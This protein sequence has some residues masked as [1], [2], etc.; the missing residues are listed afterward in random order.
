MPRFEPFNA[1][2][3][4]G[5][6]LVVDNNGAA[7]FDHGRDVK[8]MPGTCPT[9]T[10]TKALVHPTSFERYRRALT[11]TEMIHRMEQQY[12]PDA[13][14]LF[15]RDAMAAQASK[16][17]DENALPMK[18]W[19]RL[20]QLAERKDPLRPGI[21]AGRLFVHTIITHHL[22]ALTNEEIELEEL[23]KYLEFVASTKTAARVKWIQGPRKGL[24]RAYEKTF[25]DYVWDASQNKDWVRGT[26][27]VQSQSDLE[28]AVQ[29][30][31]DTIL[32]INGF[33]LPKHGYVPKYEVKP[34]KTVNPCGYSGWN[35]AITLL[36]HRYWA[37]IQANT[38]AMLYGKI[39]KK[40]FK[41]CVDY[42]ES[43]YK[44][45]QK[46]I[47]IQGGLHHAMYEIYRAEPESMEGMAAAELSVA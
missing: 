28:R 25:K 14:S 27:A 7:D 44:A 17:A 47:G 21:K 32:P 3:C 15:T 13:I 18:R 11:G 22:A 35:G 42:D 26:L 19:G 34:D 30:V 20:N 2:C 31:Y 43:E 12:G 1:R 46:E 4:C 10:C 24:K 41:K 36:G 45:L 6:T 23:G 9:G 33:T 16:E 39:P 40:E 5:G 37:E 29:V 38:Y 8:C